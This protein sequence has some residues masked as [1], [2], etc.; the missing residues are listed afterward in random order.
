[1]VPGVGK[2]GGKADALVIPGNVTGGL[3][4][5]RCWLVEWILQ[6]GIQLVEY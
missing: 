3:A 4:S 1:V 5:W 6:W 2:T